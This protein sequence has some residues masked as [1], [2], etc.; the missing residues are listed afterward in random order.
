M[1]HAEDEGLDGFDPLFLIFLEP[2]IASRVV[3]NSW[4]TKSGKLIA[5][6]KMTESHLKNAYA[7]FREPK[8]YKELQRRIA[9]QPQ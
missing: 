5:I 9:L 4:K 3:K 6:R 7:M 2:R 1:S 8:L